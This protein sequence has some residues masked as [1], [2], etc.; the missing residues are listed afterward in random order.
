M[1]RTV[2]AVRVGIRAAQFGWHV[3]FWFYLLRDEQGLCSLCSLALEAALAC[4][5]LEEKTSA[6]LPAKPR[7]AKNHTHGR[8]SSLLLRLR[9]QHLIKSG[10]NRGAAPC[11]SLHLPETLYPPGSFFTFYHHSYAQALRR[12]V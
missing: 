2:A 1:K 9:I 3:C 10:Y 5:H 12:V 6:K 4:T 7:L 8:N 11:K